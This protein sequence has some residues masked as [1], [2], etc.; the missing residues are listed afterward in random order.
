MK[1]LALLVVTL[2]SSLAAAAPAANAEIEL[3]LRYLKGLDGAV[4]IRNGSEHTAGEAEA[5][6]RLKWEK[7]AAKI[8]TAE[9]FI[10]L[11]GTQ[12]SLSGERYRIRFKDG[13][14]R[15]S[16]DVLAEQLAELRRNSAARPQG[17]ARAQRPSTARAA[18]A[19]FSR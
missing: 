12:S 4:F 18:R 7:Q 11:C 6:M 13:S 14:V 8:R 1:W 16:A 10:A 2:V 15:D 5:H 17:Q 9:D 19:A 3:L